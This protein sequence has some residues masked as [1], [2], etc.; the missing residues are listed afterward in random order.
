MK[1]SSDDPTNR[2]ANTVTPTDP[3][4]ISPVSAQSQG[5]EKPHSSKFSE[6]LHGKPDHHQDH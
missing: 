4:S 3:L 6:E 5:A 2:H 1:V